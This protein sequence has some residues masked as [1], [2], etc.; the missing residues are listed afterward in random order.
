MSAE[1]V[2][3]ASAPVRLDFAGGW[4]DVAPFASAEG[5]VVVNA[6]IELRAHAEVRPGGESWR[7]QADDLGQQI[8]LRG[9]GWST[10]DAGDL[11]LLAAAVHRAGLGPC[12]V[13]TH[14]D[15]PPGSGLGSS[16]ALGVA[17]AAA[18]DAARHVRRTPEEWAEAAFQLEAVDAAL[19]GGRQD[20][21]AA[22]LGSPQRLAFSDGR[23]VA[24][25][26]QL[27]PAFA[28]ALE[29]RLVVCYTGTSRLSS[30]TIT[31]VMQA[32][33]AGD[34][35]VVDALRLLADLADRM[36]KALLA[37]NFTQVGRLLTANWRQQQR[38]DAGI[39]TPEME[40]LERAMLAAGAL[41]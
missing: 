34:A 24:E 9:N 8:E 1:R 10:A 21:Y 7:L 5:G 2:Y 23:V 6:A 38:L 39:Q 26:L 40:R 16:G 35:T 13:R 3:R 12:A 18:L 27:D 30:T 11:K 19:P 17:L 37:G 15:A 36:A 20:Q 33:T 28:A 31:R 41:G 29:Q 14:C 22:A 25:P 32:Y 4:T